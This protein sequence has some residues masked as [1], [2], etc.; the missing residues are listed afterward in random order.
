M[1]NDDVRSSMWD[2]HSIERAS[3]LILTLV[4]MHQADAIGIVRGLLATI[5]A[6][7][8]LHDA[9]KRFTIAEMLRDAADQI[10]RRPTLVH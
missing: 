10:E 8:T 5:K 1:T 7:T 3:T 2:L 4:H 6:M 9:A